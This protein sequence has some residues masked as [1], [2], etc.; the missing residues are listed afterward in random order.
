[1]DVVL[2]VMIHSGFAEKRHK[3]Q[4]EHVESRHPGY[5]GAYQPQQDMSLVAGKSFPQNF[6][7]R[8]ETRQARRTCDGESSH[9]HRPER[10]GNLVLQRA[11][12]PHVLLVMHGVNHTAGTKK[13]QR[14]EEGM[15]HEVEDARCK[16]ADAEREKRVTK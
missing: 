3:D 6:I 11:H 7:L 8:E 16:R 5:C 9:E 10:H 2:S 4:S 15:R 13:Q 12:L 14:L 1:M